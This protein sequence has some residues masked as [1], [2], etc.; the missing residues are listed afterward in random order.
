[1]SIESFKNLFEQYET[2]LTEEDGEIKIKVWTTDPSGL[3]PYLFILPAVAIS[4]FLTQFVVDN[5]TLEIAAMVVPPI[6]L[7]VSLAFLLTYRLEKS[8]QN[9]SI[10]FSKEYLLR[11]RGN[12]TEKILFTEINAIKMEE[13]RN[14]TLKKNYGVF[15]AEMDDNTNTRVNLFE[16]GLPG[17]EF[18]KADAKKIVKFL[19]GML[20]KDK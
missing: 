18:T 17:K 14:E 5:E 4:L 10:I 15:F 3:R 1:M 12:D 2:Q 8:R 16:L 20:H 7:M 6:L 19:H 9:D 11:Q 13:K